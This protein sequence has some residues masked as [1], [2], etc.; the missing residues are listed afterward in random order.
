[1]FVA[2]A[3]LLDDGELDVITT[4]DGPKLRFLAGFPS[5][6]KGTHVERPDVEVR[7]GAVV[8][9]CADRPFDLYA[10]GDKITEL[11]ARIGVLPDALELIAPEAP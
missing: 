5:V 4:A 2:P 1:M 11:P 6:F 10:D 7:R 9:V 8:E 3:A